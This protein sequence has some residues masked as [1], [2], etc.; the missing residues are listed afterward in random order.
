MID[1]G[2]R[3]IRRFRHFPRDF[4][5]FALCRVANVH[6]VRDK[7][8]SEIAANSRHAAD[9]VADTVGIKTTGGGRPALIQQFRRAVETFL[10]RVLSAKCCVGS[11]VVSDVV[12]ATPHA[13]LVFNVAIRPFL[14]EVTVIFWRRGNEIDQ[15]NVDAGWA[16]VEGFFLI[17]HVQ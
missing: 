14:R 9:R 12:F 11:P 2:I 5:V 4:F 3:V 15:R 6:L 16:A 10:V 8:R 7:A 1:V 13:E 17:T